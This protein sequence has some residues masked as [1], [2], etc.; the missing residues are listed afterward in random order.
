MS[1]CVSARGLLDK[2]GERVLIQSIVK[3]IERVDE[4][5]LQSA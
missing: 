5:A 4:N 1:A 2:V 3:S